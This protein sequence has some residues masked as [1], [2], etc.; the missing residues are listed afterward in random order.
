MLFHSEFIIFCLCISILSKCIPYLLIY[1]CLCFLLV[2]MADD[3]Q[4]I[5][6]MISCDVLKEKLENLVKQ[7]K[8]QKKSQV[9]STELIPS[10][11]HI[12]NDLKGDV[13]VESNN[14]NIVRPLENYVNLTELN[15]LKTSLNRCKLKG[16]HK[17]NLQINRKQE[18]S[19]ENN[20]AKVIE[21][22]HQELKSPHSASLKQTKCVRTEANVKRSESWQAG[23]KY[24]KT[25]PLQ[26]RQVEARLAGMKQLER[27]IPESNV[28]DNVKVENTPKFSDAESAKQED[29]FNVD[30]LIL[31]SI[32]RTDPKQLS[33][34]CLTGD[35]KRNVMSQ[36]G[37]D[38]YE[39]LNLLPP[40]QFRDVPPPLPPEAFR[41][42][43][44]PIDN[45][46][47]YVLE[48]VHENRREANRRNYDES[49][50]TKRKNNSYHR[51]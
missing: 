10:N 35:Q 50:K 33:G 40:T 21:M 26:L 30:S 32:S 28:H 29:W 17:F 25:K 23:S 45:I 31:N 37:D 22:A 6:K 24:M 42:P 4:N 34:R 13:M 51:K 2:G 15:E 8:S 18:L 47:Y 16:K 14:N 1:K 5:H 7:S 27:Q 38:I 49:F 12:W 43:P 39:K 36:N 20:Q 46:L 19:V 48:S 9:K 41:D 44:E 11:E 3:K